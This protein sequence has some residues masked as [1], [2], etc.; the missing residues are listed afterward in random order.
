MEYYGIKEAAERTGLSAYTLR[1]YDK[2]G[3]LPF[4]ERTKTG[5][6]RFKEE[7]FEWLNVIGC[8]KDTG[9]RLEEIRTFT[10]WCMEG[11]GTLEQ[12][13]EMFYERKREVENQI[14]K[15]QKTMQNIEKKIQYY[16]AAV[17]EGSGKSHKKSRQKTG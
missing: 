5:L 10:E 13:L 1:Y 7:D 3:L 14:V 4:V 12:R 15:L 17:E 11:D 6:R 8:L 2:M 9:M 16:E